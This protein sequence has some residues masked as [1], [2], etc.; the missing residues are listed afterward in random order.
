MSS[1]EPNSHASRVAIPVVG[2]GD[3]TGTGV[4]GGVRS[5]ASSISSCVNTDTTERNDR[6]DINHNVDRNSSHESDSKSRDVRTQTLGTATTS[7][8]ASSSAPTT[9]NLYNPFIGFMSSGFSS[10]GSPHFA[11]APRSPY[12]GM[13]SSAGY[14]QQQRTEE[15]FQR[16]YFQRWFQSIFSP[17]PMR[18]NGNTPS[19]TEAEF[20]AMP[21]FVPN[22]V[23]TAP[24]NPSTENK[25]D[26]GRS[27]TS[28]SPQLAPTS[29]GVQQILIREGNPNPAEV[30][31][32]RSYYGPD[33]DQFYTGGE[34]FLQQFNDATALTFKQPHQKIAAFRAKMAGPARGW[35]NQLSLLQRVTWEKVVQAFLQ[36]S[37]RLGYGEDYQAQLNRCIQK[38]GEF[39][40]SFYT[41]LKDIQER[42]NCAALMAAPP[43]TRQTIQESKAK[44]QQALLAC[45]ANNINE[46]EQ[47]LSRWVQTVTV[48]EF[49]VPNRITDDAVRT[50]WRTHLLDPL[51]LYV[52]M[53]AD[54]Y[55]SRPFE[56]LLQ[57]VALEERLMMLNKKLTPASVAAASVDSSEGSDSDAEPGLFESNRKRKR[58]NG[59]DITL[60]QPK[61]ESDTGS[62]EEDDDHSNSSLG[63]GGANPEEPGDQDDQDDQDQ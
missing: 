23:T 12:G 27:Y 4:N 38:E 7:S 39:S 19:T 11:L 57:V 31:N 59:N 26:N 37:I 41:R 9:N 63:E 42:A 55:S 44:R 16:Q 5:E 15:D 2:T 8:A 51:R 29:S 17:G 33:E 48:Q 61:T 3:S 45:Q 35:Y 52:Q 46:N 36:Y 30:A 32:L 50:Q 34:D 28:D 22:P 47:I 6:T 13:W 43:Y 62:E 18:S 54:P 1:G 60:S 56:D 53:K 25:I 49:A 21:G 10:G 24:T 40:R 14:S 20:N 58:S